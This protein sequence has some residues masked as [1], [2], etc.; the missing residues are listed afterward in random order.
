MAEGKFSS[1]RM[2]V[3]NFGKRADV[4][5]NPLAH[6]VQGLICSERKRGKLDAGLGKAEA[7]PDPL[8]PQP[9]TP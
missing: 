4:W 3:K 7:N 9:N 1:A 2:T 8:H 5:L 6:N